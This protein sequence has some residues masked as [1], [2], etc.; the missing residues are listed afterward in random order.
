MKCTEMVLV[1]NEMDDYTEP[2]NTSEPIL[3]KSEDGD[4]RH[5]GNYDDQ[6]EEESN[7]SKEISNNRPRRAQQQTK[8][9]REKPTI[10]KL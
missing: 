2:D 7:S 3:A 8:N 9:N 1:Q 5:H 6:E 4:G 10:H